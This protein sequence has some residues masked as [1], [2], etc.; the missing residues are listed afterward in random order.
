MK[1]T[2]PWM[3]RQQRRSRA[4]T[5]AAHNNLHIFD[6]KNDIARLEYEFALAGLAISSKSGV[7][8]AFIS[9]D[10]KYENL[11]RKNAGLGIES[12]PIPP[13]MIGGTFVRKSKHDA[14]LAY[15]FEII[16]P[17]ILTT[18]AITTLMRITLEYAKSGEAGVLLTRAAHLCKTNRP[19]GQEIDAV[20]YNLKCLSLCRISGTEVRGA[21]VLEYSGDSPAFFKYELLGKDGI[22]IELSERLQ[23]GTKVDSDW[24]YVRIP[25]EDRNKLKGTAQ[26][27]HLWL[28]AWLRSY[29]KKSIMIN[30]I[31]NNEHVFKKPV[32]LSDAEEKDWMAVHRNIIKTDSKS[33]NILDGWSI[34]SL[35]CCK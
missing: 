20:L 3:K 12:L 14:K 2:E 1:S 5:I 11:K 6:K 9:A 24:Q 27:L 32:F 7:S 8:A 16:C 33:L 23:G 10:K 31:L 19:S 35:N 13:S 21:R 34:E 25:L 28:T 17:N 29:S 22:R 15:R 4:A 18:E 30:T 26:D